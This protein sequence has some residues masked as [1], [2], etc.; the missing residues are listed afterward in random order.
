MVAVSLALCSALTF[1]LSTSLQHRAATALADVAPGR[2]LGRLLRRREWLVG[3]CLSVLAFGLHAWALGSGPLSLV[4]PVIISGVV[5]AV[6]F[7]SALDRRWP[8][9]REL[10]WVALTWSG[11]VVFIAGT[12]APESTHLPAHAPLV[13]GV[14]AV[15]AAVSTRRG[16]Q[17]ATP[18]GRGLWLGTAA[19]ILFG[20][21]AA[22]IKLVLVAA[23]HHAGALSV[24]WPMTAMLLAGLWAVAL[25][26]R[27]YQTTRLSVS[28]PVL[29]VVDV[30]VALAFAGIVLGERPGLSPAGL[31]AQCLGLFA[32]SWGVRQLARVEE[33]AH[34]APDQDALP[35][36][37][38]DPDLHPAQSLATRSP[39]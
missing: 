25:N 36:P 4:Q 26:Q 22:M 30:L 5:F 18:E 23:S 7:R 16:A 17:A 39:S 37:A 28:M 19:G 35:P 13:T 6:L 27:A 10:G 12:G 24:A 33:R 15:V 11:L 2:L 21:V 14:L 8:S 3:I 9:R 1:G 29:N 20:L 32:I 38:A 31:A 34:P